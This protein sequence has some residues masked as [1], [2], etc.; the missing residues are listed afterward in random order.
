MKRHI[1]PEEVG[2]HAL[3]EACR[4][5]FV[6]S[7]RYEER[8]TTELEEISRAAAVTD[9][10]RHGFNAPLYGKRA[11]ILLAEALEHARCFRLVFGD[12]DEAVAVLS[13]DAFA[14]GPDRP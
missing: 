9:L 1:L 4:I 7:P 11:P 6:V 13:G 2:L 10:W 14:G 12:L 3:A 8:A 5:G